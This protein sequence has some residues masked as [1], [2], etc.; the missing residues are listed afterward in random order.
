MFVETLARDFRDTQAL[1]GMRNYVEILRRWYEI[2]NPS[3][4]ACVFYNLIYHSSSS[5]SGLLGLSPKHPSWWVSSAYAG[6]KDAGVR[7]CDGTTGKTQG[8][9]AEPTMLASRGS[10]ASPPWNH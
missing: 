5:L 6:S 4:Y 3:D 9:Q 2:I 1:G 10:Q 7:Y 8:R